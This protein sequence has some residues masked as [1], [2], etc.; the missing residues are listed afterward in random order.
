MKIL[1]HETIIQKMDEEETAIAHKY[2]I[3]L[4]HTAEDM[5]W[6]TEIPKIYKVH[7]ISGNLIDLT[8][9]FKYLPKRFDVFHAKGGWEAAKY[10]KFIIENYH[11][12]PEKM[13]FA[14]AHKV[15]W[16]LG[17]IIKTL[18]LIPWDEHEYL[19]LSR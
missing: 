12:L 8:V 6:V 3:V 10:L 5:V 19:A 14:H 9:Y 4:A 13:L 1:G 15:S 7:V 2:A 16:H 18:P 11:Q 17:D